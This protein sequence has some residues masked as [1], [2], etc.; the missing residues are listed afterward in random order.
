LEDSPLVVDLLNSRYKLK[1]RI[2][3]ALPNNQ[4]TF[5]YLPPGKYI[6]RVIKD[7][8]DNNKWDTGNYLKKIQPEEVIYLPEEIDVRANWDVNQVFDPIQIRLDRLKSSTAS[9]VTEVDQVP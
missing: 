6:I 1:R 4:H 8:N 7:V 9:E 5:E 3:K 2:T